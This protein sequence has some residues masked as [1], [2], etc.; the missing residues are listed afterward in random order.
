MN[1]RWRNVITIVIFVMLI[2]IGF[3]ITFYEYIEQ[4]DLV[5]LITVLLV[6]I[7]GTVVSE[8]KNNDV[9]YYISFGITG[10]LLIYTGFILILAS[11]KMD[12]LLAPIAVMI[13]ITL[14][15]FGVLISAFAFKKAYEVRAKKS[16]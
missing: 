10:I 12:S 8:I 5:L 1:P 11:S 6:I 13:S 7:I 15:L 4:T 14:I 16:E 2:F 3:V 9:L